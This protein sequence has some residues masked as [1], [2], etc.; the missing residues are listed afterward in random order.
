[1]GAHRISARNTD[2]R[3]KK[4]P[5]DSRHHRTVLWALPSLFSTCVQ[6]RN[7]RRVSRTNIAVLFPPKN[8]PDSGQCLLPQGPRCMDMVLGQSETH[9]GVQSSSLLPRTQRSGKNMASH[10]ITRHAQ[11][12]FPNSRRTSFSPNLNLPKHPEKSVSSYGLPPS[13]SVNIMSLYLCNDK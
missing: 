5:Q 9:R 4:H 13:L 3:P 7:L 12:V 6:R 2:Y 1:M 8:I 10:T 11:Q